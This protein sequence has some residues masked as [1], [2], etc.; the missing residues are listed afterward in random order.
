MRRSDMV[1]RLDRRDDRWDIVIIGGGATGVGIAVDATS[2]GYD[3][4]RLEQHDFGKGT[5]RACAAGLSITTEVEL[6]VSASQSAVS[7]MMRGC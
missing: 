3:V 4:L 7:S 5:S 6:G 2:R 1:A